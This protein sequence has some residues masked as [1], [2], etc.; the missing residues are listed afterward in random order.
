MGNIA[1]PY[2]A[3]A[4]ASFILLAA[5]TAHAQVPVL[6]P[7]D[8]KLRY[9]VYWNN[10]PLGR[11][12]LEGKEDSFG[13]TVSAD[14]KT[15]GIVRMFDAT[16]SVITASGRIAEPGDDN[17]LTQKT[18][19]AHRYD[20]TSTNEDEVKTTTLRYGEDGVLTKVK[21]NPP[22]D[23]ANRPPVPLEQA[24]KGLDPLTAML[25]LRYQLR[26]NIALNE[27]KTVMRSYDGA[28]LA[29]FIF[30]VVSR[31]QMEVMDEHREAINVVMTRT[32]IAGYKAKEL[33]KYEEGDPTVHVFFS[34]D[35]AFIP[36]GAEIKLRFGSISVKLT[37]ME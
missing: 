36:L 31:A 21:R 8:H 37:E 3:M 2:K 7:F 19:Y 32:P 28:R 5:G 23:P 35:A 24:S 18:F 20:S 16:Q 14:T 15:R 34:A 29:D 12:R 9:D 22:D 1:R 11:I 30:T 27:R 17:E 33:K 4:L 6:E 25:A 13:Y 26:D 10:I